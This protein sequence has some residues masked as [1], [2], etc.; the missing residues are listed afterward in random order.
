MLQQH[1]NVHILSWKRE[2][3]FDDRKSISL[4]VNCCWIQ[5]SRSNW[6][7]QLVFQEQWSFATCFFPPSKNSFNLLQTPKIRHAMVSSDWDAAPGSTC[8]A[9]LTTRQLLLEIHHK[10]AQQATAGSQKKSVQKTQREKIQNMWLPAVFF[11]HKCW[12]GLNFSWCCSHSNGR[13]CRSRSVG[14][15][16]AAV[17]TSTSWLIFS[18]RASHPQNKM[19]KVQP[20]SR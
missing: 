15:P 6:F 17:K 11:L 1:H 3:S 18:S 10:D 19:F 9:F 20:F 7:S 14:S 4:K 2:K 12:L 13:Y 16:P 8:E 5:I